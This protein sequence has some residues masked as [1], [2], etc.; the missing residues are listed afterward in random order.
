[1]SKWVKVSK[2]SWGLSTSVAFFDKV[3][4]YAGK[5]DH[6]GISV[7]VNFYDRALTLEILNLYCGVEIWRSS[8]D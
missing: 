8:D 5:T 2:S 3:N 6:W 4:F 1:M 7:D